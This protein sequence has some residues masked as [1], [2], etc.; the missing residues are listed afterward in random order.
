LFEVKWD[1]VRTIL[2]TDGGAISLRS[3]RGRDVTEVYPELS[4][5]ARSEACVLDGEIVA[6]DQAGRPSFAALQQRMNLSGRARAVE[7]ARAIPVTFV[8]FDLLFDGEETTD[9]PIE[10]RLERL[11][12]IDLPVPL[13]GS[14]VIETDG[15][16][17]YAAVATEGL[18]GVVAKR[19]GSRYRPGVR[20]P[21]WRKILYLRIIRA[22]VCGFTPGER[23]RTGTFGSLVLGLWDGPR[24]R[25]VGSVG[26]GFDDAALRAIRTSLEEMAIAGNPFHADP[27]L[28]GATWVAPH[29]VARIEFKEWTRAGRL[30]APSFKG[31][32]SE[33]TE[34]I[35]WEGE[36]P[37]S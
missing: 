29:L 34:T 1:G 36:G 32:V 12:A 9:L 11:A 6:L 21:D 7:A 10:T 16:A 18:E 28:P 4:G 30:R 19:R 33:P 17:L 8:V 26:T 13:V 31:F 25:W 22:V 24:L 20:S 5:F 37:E 2:T 23:G 15:E 14:E 27:D 3:R 35:T